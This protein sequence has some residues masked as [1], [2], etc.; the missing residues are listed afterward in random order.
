M[1]VHLYTTTARA[2]LMQ[3]TA[4]VEVESLTLRSV[5]A[6]PLA[7]WRDVN[8][9]PTTRSRRLAEIAYGFLLP[10]PSTP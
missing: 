6:R 8:L 3:K 1:V 4:G 2:A 5:L 7:A 9:A 10:A